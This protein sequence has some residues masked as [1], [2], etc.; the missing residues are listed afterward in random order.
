MVL[1][2]LDIVKMKRTKS[3]FNNRFI[4]LFTAQK[5]QWYSNDSKLPVHSL[6]VL[7]YKVMQD[8]GHLPMQLV[9]GVST[10]RS[11]PENCP[12][13][14]GDHPNATSCLAGR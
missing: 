11:N 10:L 5:I 14:S 13:S 9:K 2:K 7:W 4:L 3:L 1:L 12:S 6:S 8:V